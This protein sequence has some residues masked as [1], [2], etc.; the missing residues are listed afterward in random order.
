VTNIVYIATSL[1]GYIADKDGKLDWLEE[2]PNPDKLDCGWAEFMNRIQAIVMGRNTFDTVCSF[3]GKWPYNKPVFVLS[4]SLKSIPD[5]CKDK[6][7]IINGALADVINRIRDK[8]FSE[9]YIDGG[10]TIQNFLNEN[11]IDEMIITSMPILLGSGARLFGELSNPQRF[12]HIKTDVM[13][14][15]MVKTHYRKKEGVI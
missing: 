13:L 2:T 12:E 7:E 6:V 14:N 4:N 8:G 3:N 9:L 5:K 1:D 11:L 10:V 15:A